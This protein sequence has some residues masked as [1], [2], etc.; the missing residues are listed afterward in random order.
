MKFPCITLSH[1][2]IFFHVNAN[3]FVTKYATQSIVT[4]Y[5]DNDKFTLL[6]DSIYGIVWAEPFFL[7]PKMSVVLMVILLSGKF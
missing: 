4:I 2:F 1:T 6:N 5:H 7:K 3:I